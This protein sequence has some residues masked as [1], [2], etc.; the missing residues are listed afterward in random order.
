MIKPEEVHSLL[1]EKMRDRQ[2]KL[3]SIQYLYSL[4]ILAKT[5]GITMWF[6]EDALTAACNVAHDTDL[7]H[8]A[9]ICYGAEVLE[10]PMKIQ[11]VARSQLIGVDKR[12]QNKELFAAKLKET[13]SDYSSKGLMESVI[14]RDDL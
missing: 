7:V 8:A 14:W 12:C 9:D 6:T 4:C 2:G 1:T 13:L 10:F 5:D 3:L 11:E